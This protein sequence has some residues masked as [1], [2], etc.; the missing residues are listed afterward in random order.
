MP[1][2]I[3]AITP[4]A[5]TAPAA[6]ATPASTSSI[7]LRPDV[8]DLA[9]ALGLLQDLPGT[10]IGTGFNLI[11]R[12]NFA[13]VDGVGSDHFLELNLT[14]EITRFDFIGAPIP[15]CGLAQPDITLFGI[16]YL[17][18]VSDAVTLGALHLDPGIWINIPATTQPNAPLPNAVAR[19]ST[20]PHGNAMVAQGQ[21]IN[22]AG[23]P[24]FGPV[25]VNPFR[26]GGGPAIDFPEL[27]LDQP[28][29]FRTTPLPPANALSE[30]LDL[31]FQD[32]VTNP[33]LLLARTI[34]RQTIFNTTEISV[35]TSATI[36]VTNTAPITTPNGEGGVENIAF[37]NSVTGTSPPPAPPHTLPNADAA[38]VFATF[39]VEEVQNPFGDGTFFQLQYSQTV[40]LNFAGLTWPHVSVATLIRS[41][42][43]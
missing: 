22:S 16:H 28:S 30:A 43:V 38:E 18:Q 35:A 24:I 19:L 17:Q 31:T 14:Q 9:N 40:Y 7:R 3:P 36:P 23:P 42:V 20:I 37:L 8:G 15:N 34:E 33:A 5:P 41:S 25:N 32:V 1:D 4:A 12:P 11:W 6:P 10:W 29:N 27:H 2:V 39:W 26:I 13:P 21:A